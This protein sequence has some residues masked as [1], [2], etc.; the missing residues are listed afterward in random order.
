MYKVLLYNMARQTFTTNIYTEISDIPSTIQ[1]WKVETQSKLH[2]DGAGAELQS[3]NSY[4][5]VYEMLLNG[6]NKLDGVGLVDNRPS[7]DQPLGHHFV[8]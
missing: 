7:T 6:L 4:I 1:W 5:K 2:G 8:M 3:A